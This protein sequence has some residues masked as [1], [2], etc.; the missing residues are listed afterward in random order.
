VGS[1][2][3][4]EFLTEAAKSCGWSIGTAIGGKVD[5]AL[6]KWIK[7]REKAAKKARKR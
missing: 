3:I 5:A 6:G 2:L 7:R 1:K 4:R